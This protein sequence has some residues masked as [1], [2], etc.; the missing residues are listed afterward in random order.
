MGSIVLQV[1]IS[2]E[3]N[4]RVK[5]VAAG[6]VSEWVRGLLEQAV[7]G[8]EPLVKPVVVV[9][10]KAAPVVSEHPRIDPRAIERVRLHKETRVCGRCARTVETWKVKDGL[11]ICER[12][13]ADL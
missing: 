3:L 9:E 8:V 13:W 6:N 7:G 12:H 5:A 10:K 4:E 2:A 1:R 11:A